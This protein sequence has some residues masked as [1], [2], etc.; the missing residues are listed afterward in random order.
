[1]TDVLP[2]LHADG[3]GALRRPEADRVRHFRAVFRAAAVWSWVVSVAYFAGDTLDEPFLRQ[4]LPRAQPRVIL[5]MAV[6]PTFLFGFAFW[7]VSRDLS[8]NHAIAGVGAA[9]SILAFVSFFTRAVSGEIPFF[10]LSAAV[11][12]LTFGL[13]LLQFLFWARRVDFGGAGPTEHDD[14]YFSPEA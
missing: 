7:W 8:K 3:N 12:D 1:V 11:V 6:L 9:G 5:D 2:A 4:M 13:L 14:A 10:L